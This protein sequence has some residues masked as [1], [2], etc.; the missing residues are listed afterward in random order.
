VLIMARDVSGTSSTSSI[1]IKRLMHR[2]QDERV[3]SHAKVII[4]APDC[5]LV[6]SRFLVGARKLFSQPIDV[7]EITVRLVLV[8]LVQFIVV[9]PLIVESGCGC[10]GRNI[11]VG[12]LRGR[13]LLGRMRKRDMTCVSISLAVQRLRDRLM[14]VGRMTQPSQVYGEIDLTLLASQAFN[15]H[16]LSL[17]RSGSVQLGPVDAGVVST[18]TAESAG[19][20]AIA[21]AS[22]LYGKRLSHNWAATTEN[23]KVGHA[24]GTRRNVV[25]GGRRRERA[26]SGGGC[27]GKK[28]AHGSRLSQ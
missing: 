4:G 23:L 10:S 25:T 5:N 3:T 7:V 24:A 19:K 8:L 13:W 27:L 1:V 14:M 9:E 22:T 15:V 16:S 6:F 12:R 21:D 20:S 18:Y 28:R 26:E 17:L 11:H 2:L